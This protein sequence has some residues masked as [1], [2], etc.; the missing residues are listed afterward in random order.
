MHAALMTREGVDSYLRTEA[1]EWAKRRGNPEAAIPSLQPFKLTYAK[2]LADY[3]FV[4]QAQMYIESIRLC[5]G[6]TGGKENDKRTCAPG[7]LASLYT[8]AFAEALDVFEDRVCISQGTSP[9]WL[10]KESLGE[11]KTNTVRRTWKFMSKGML[12]ESRTVSEPSKPSTNLDSVSGPPLGN[13]SPADQ[14]E[15]ANMSFVTAAGPPN[16]KVTTI[17]HDDD[18]NMSFVTA[19]GPP[20]QKVTPIDHGDDVNMS[21]VTAAADVLDVTSCTHKEH[22]KNELHEGYVNVGKNT[23]TMSLNS[24]KTA[25][26][27]P[28]PI[29][30]APVRNEVNIGMLSSVSE[31]GM[32]AKGK[33]QEAQSAPASFAAGMEQLPKGEHNSKSKSDKSGGKQPTPTKSPQRAPASERSGGRWSMKDWLTKRFNPEAKVADVGDSMQARYDP[34]LKR[35]IFPGDNPEEIAK[36]LAPPPIM[37]KDTITAKAEPVAAK[38]D[39]PLSSLMAPPPMRST[40]RPRYAD[41]LA[42]MGAV[43]PGRTPTMPSFSVSPPMGSSLEPPKFTVFQAKAPDRTDASPA[44]KKGKSS[45]PPMPDK[46]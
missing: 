1:L 29:I 38:N 3:G 26:G 41:P 9:S 39:D 16:Q 43:H 22:D 30:S 45:M 13:M 36:P 23:Q 15:D 11:T 2:L 5:T 35:W 21:F 42:S 24:P 31:T 27:G 17:D 14:G 28:P 33:I 44:D 19:A 4:S 46:K 37:K 20:N 25:I 7:N 18:V 32:N 6:M 12:G 8:K 10:R 34:K 40:P